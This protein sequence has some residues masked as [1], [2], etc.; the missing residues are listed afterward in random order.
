MLQTNEGEKLTTV[1]G[2]LNLLC[3]FP[4]GH[5][6]RANIQCGYRKV[7]CLFK[8]ETSEGRDGHYGNEVGTLR[9]DIEINI[10]RQ[11]HIQEPSHNNSI[12]LVGE[13]YRPY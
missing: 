13:P 5:W 6:I 1:R 12:D 8:Q 7:V 3:T 9:R 2:C 11:K 4:G 10:D